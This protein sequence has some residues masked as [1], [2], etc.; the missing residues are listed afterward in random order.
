MG[1]LK[2]TT[3]P[4]TAIV[5]LDKLKLALILNGVNPQIGGVL[6]SGPKG[7]GK[8]TV[9]RALAD[10]LPE[11]DMIDECRFG[12]N[13]ENPELYCE[14]CRSRLNNGQKLSSIKRKMRV[15]NLPLST[16]EDRLIGSLDI[17]Q[18]LQQGIQ[19]L[20]PGILAE[21]HQNVLY[22][23]E[24]N[25]LPD[26]LVDDLLD[27]AATKINTIEREGISISHPS[28]FVLIGTMNPEE[29]ELRPQLLDRFSLHVAVGTNHTI[30]DRMELVRRNL[31][32]ERDPSQFHDDW[33]AEQEN[34]RMKIE[35]A[36]ELLDQVTLSES[37][38]R[39]IALACDA[40]E[41]DGVRPDIVISKTAITHAALEGR[42]EVTLEDMRLASQ[43][44]LSHRTRRGGLLEPP[45]SDDIDRAI[46]KASEVAKKNDRRKSPTE[47]PKEEDEEGEKGER[48]SGGRFGR[49]SG[50][51]Q[52]GRQEGKKKRPVK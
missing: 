22:V 46:T 3:L 32:F 23:D 42:T 43:L 35:R 50:F 4:F 47:V 34:L 26:H 52:Y 24:V 44:A 15:V 7:T 10:L 21:A 29:G 20:R 39:A 8:T 30:E 33:S 25:L 48:R 37:N 17:E 38:L 27:A 11:V 36:K 28:D 18:V 19:A 45:S 2:R 40:L 31:A 49:Q 9:V 16:T 5:G 12:C 41:V 51:A 6:I 1:Q 13:P 14:D